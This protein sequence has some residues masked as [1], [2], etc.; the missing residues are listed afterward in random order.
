MRLTL[1]M[2]LRVFPLRI[3]FHTVQK[4]EFAFPILNM[5]MNLATYKFYASKIYHIFGEAEKTIG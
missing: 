2:L 3:L 1:K 5:L 4:C